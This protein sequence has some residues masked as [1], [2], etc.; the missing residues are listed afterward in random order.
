[1]PESQP[2]NCLQYNSNSP[3]H[4][5]DGC[6]QP[7]QTGHCL[8][9]AK[10]YPQAQV[11]ITTDCV[12]CYT[13][14]IVHGSKLSLGFFTSKGNMRPHGQDGIPVSPSP[15]KEPAGDLVGSGGVLL[16]VHPFTLIIEVARHQLPTLSAGQRGRK[17]FSDTSPSSLCRIKPP[18]LTVDIQQSFI[19][20]ADTTKSGCVRVHNKKYQYS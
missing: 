5:D 6:F 2:W 9:P 11:Q 14:A 10:A 17:S 20:T 15:P 4:D 19:P 16:T 7:D 3:F 18:R 13:E 12:T 1:M 8:T